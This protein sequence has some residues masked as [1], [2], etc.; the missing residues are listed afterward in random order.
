M[1]AVLDSDTREPL[2]T[3]VEAA[4]LLAM[5]PRTL[6]GYRRKGGG[7]TFVT[8]SRNVV[9]YRRS[10]LDSWVSSRAAPHTAKARTLLS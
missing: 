10:D 5:S 8:L 4:A 6:E 1:A 9:R 2:I 7:P 3:T